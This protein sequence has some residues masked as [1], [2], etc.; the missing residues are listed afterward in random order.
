MVVAEGDAVAERALGVGRARA[1]FEAEATADKSKGLCRREPVK[2]EVRRN[3]DGRWAE[4]TGR[5]RRGVGSV[6]TTS[7]GVQLGG[8]RGREGR[9]DKV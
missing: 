6:D 1:S 3:W 8:S 5:C 9:D 4:P 2:L 7:Y